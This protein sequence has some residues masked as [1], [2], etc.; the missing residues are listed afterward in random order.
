M[1]THP[2]SALTTDEI[3]QRNENIAIEKKRVR[4]E[5]IATLES[6]GVFIEH[7]DNTFHFTREMATQLIAATQLSEKLS[8]KTLE[9]ENKEGEFVTIKVIDS[10]KICGEVMQKFI[11]IRKEC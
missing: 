10:Y 9:W 3:T 6:K 4:N 1:I 11:A 5:K 8:A 2:I 7:K